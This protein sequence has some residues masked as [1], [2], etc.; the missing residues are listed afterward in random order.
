MQHAK[1]T[2]LILGGR[3]KDRAKQNR[4]QSETAFVR[5]KEVG[6]MRFFLLYSNNLLC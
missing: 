5:M 6:W 2:I 3:R 4:P 1:K